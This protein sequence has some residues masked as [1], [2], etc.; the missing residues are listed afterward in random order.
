[1]SGRVRVRCD[2]NDVACTFLFQSLPRIPKTFVWTQSLPRVHLYKFTC[3]E[4][5]SYVTVSSCIARVA[6]AA[7]SY[8]HTS[9]VTWSLCVGLWNHVLVGVRVGATWQIRC[10][11]LCAWRCVFISNHFDQLFSLLYETRRSQFFHVAR[12]HLVWEAI[13]L[14][15]N[16]TRINFVITYSAGLWNE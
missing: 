6:H 8:T 15:I 3:T 7:Y 2:T 4:F 5:N 16:F 1:M 13:S 11:N 12:R 10:N 14:V 9:L